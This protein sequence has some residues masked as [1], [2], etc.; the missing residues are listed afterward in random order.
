MS[1]YFAEQSRENRVAKYELG[2]AKVVDANKEVIVA[3]KIFLLSGQTYN[4]RWELT[5][6]NGTYKIANAK[7]MGFSLTYLQRGLFTYYIFQAQG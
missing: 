3:T 7:V 5:W 6:R 4:V 1:R 2:E